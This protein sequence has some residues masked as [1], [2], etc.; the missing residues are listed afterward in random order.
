MTL[1]SDQCTAVNCV[2]DAKQ[3]SIRL[4]QHSP[5]V[6]RPAWWT[7]RSLLQ[8]WKREISD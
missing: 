1:A 7:D 2:C 4:I 8:C 3:S 5:V 6:Y